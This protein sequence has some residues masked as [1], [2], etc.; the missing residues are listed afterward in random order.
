MK[1]LMLAVTIAVSSS[2][3]PSA[4]QSIDGTLERLGEPSQLGFLKGLRFQPGLHNAIVG[5]LQTLPADKARES[6][7]ERLRS[8]QA[9]AGALPN[10]VLNATIVDKGNLSA[11]L[12]QLR[13]R[14]RS[15]VPLSPNGPLAAALPDVDVIRIERSRQTN[16]ITRGFTPTPLLPDQSIIPAGLAVSERTTPQIIHGL[17]RAR[18]TPAQ[19]TSSPAQ[20]REM[21]C[22]SEGGPNCPAFDPSRFSAI[23]EVSFGSDGSVCTGTMIARG[24]IITAAHCFLGPGLTSPALTTR[25]ALE[26]GGGGSKFGAFQSLNVSRFVDERAGAVNFVAFPG[27]PTRPIQA[28][29][30]HPDYSPI[31]ND[32]P[33]TGSLN[34]IALVQYESSL[35]L[36]EKI[37]SSGS[38]PLAIPKLSYSGAV[39]ILGYGQTE[40]SATAAPL[41]NL[42][43]PEADV[44]AGNGRLTITKPTIRTFCQGDSGGPAISGLV[45]GCPTE[46]SPMTLAGVISYHGGDARDARGCMT[47]QVSDFTD[48]GSPSIRNFICGVVGNA[49]EGCQ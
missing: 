37:A 1:R 29:I 30:T 46:T 2:Y 16:Y 19:C 47:S 35:I 8:D 34:D 18:L 41:V 45:R 22:L 49:V 39:T 40:A 38:R 24:W 7:L 5:D 32:L 33:Q 11:S 14:A 17:K 23:A 48:V 21:A 28:V 13:E 26:Q 10:S 44:R 20:L 3:L 31:G 27:F 43:W 4:A 9:A 12:A 15:P 25:K 42:T 6:V 36:D